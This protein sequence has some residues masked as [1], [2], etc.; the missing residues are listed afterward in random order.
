MTLVKNIALFAICLVCTAFAV[1]QN[2]A[3]RYEIDAKRIGVTPYDKDALPRSREFLRLD[4]TY[5]VGWFYQ[6]VYLQDRSV[7]QMGYQRSLGPLRT[8]F[9]RIEKDYSALL[10]NLYSSPMYYMQNN[11]RY[12][13]Y[14]VLA[15]KLRETYEYLEMPDSAV[16]VLQQVDKKN[17]RRDFFG[18]AGLKAWIIHRNR[19]YTQEK[20]GFLSNSVA[21]NEALALRSC[22]N[23]LGRIRRNAAQNNLWFG[24]GHS[25][26]D[27]MGVYHYLAL[28]HCYQKNYDSSEYY[29]ERMQN[30]G[31]ISYNNYGNMKAEIGEFAEAID[32]YGRDKYKYGSAKSL[33]EPF[34]YLPTLYVYGGRTLEAI[35]TAK[36]AIDAS[37]SSPGFGWYNIALARS[38]LYNGQL[39]SAD[40]T[41]KKAA[42]FK[43][44]HIGTTLSQPQYDFTIGLLRLMWYHR[45]I[46]LLK[47][48]D[49]GWWYK[50]ASL[51]A[52][53]QVQAQKYTH[54]YLLATQL[55]LNPERARIIYDLF[56]G[57]S[58][59]GYDEIW[60]LM[61]RYSPRYFMKLMVDYI[62]NDPRVKIKKYFQ[63]Y[64][65]RLSWEAGNRN[66][67]QEKLE[68]LLN[69]ARLDTAHEKLFLGRLYEGLA[70]SY[71]TTAT[72]TKQRG[73]ITNIMEQYPQLLPFSGLPVAVYLQINGLQDDI[74]N[75]VTAELKNCNINWQESA[76]GHAEA[77]I[78]FKKKGIKYEVE[79]RLRSASGKSVVFGE[80]FMFKDAAGAG[81]EIALRLFG[82]TGA[83]ELET[84]P[85]KQT[86]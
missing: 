57:E 82:K 39:D 83:Q 74:T 42:A 11:Q 80:R 78:S 9:L 84:L 63:L 79:L 47:F 23:G 18:T 85:V 59:V 2:P 61:K 7:D 4:S 13:D 25:N 37:N 10:K 60:Y 35:K 76:A 62:G 36:E 86:K 44:V 15:S 68:T 41:L 70:L 6:G 12:N 73:M 75:K 1:A 65:A 38:Y 19:F 33:M 34:Y 3:A 24:E 49:R 50:P 40:I 27:E 56:C 81:K 43:E 54:E 64:E 20:F 21:E 69:S 66:A 71:T 58:T 32:F 45:Q 28:L 77:T 29:Y 46:D 31:A 16:W 55:A 17:F 5:Y 26:Y 8:A 30:M 22:Y 53:A 52:L 14:L 51:Y 72:E 67:A 48:F